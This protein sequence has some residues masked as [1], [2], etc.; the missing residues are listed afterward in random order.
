MNNKTLE[1]KNKQLE[2]QIKSL[3]NEIKFTNQ[4]R[5]ILNKTVQIFIYWYFLGILSFDLFRSILDK[6]YKIVMQLK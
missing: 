4:K 5:L 6:I 1:E 2:N 3:L